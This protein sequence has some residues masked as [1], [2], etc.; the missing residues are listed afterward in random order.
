MHLQSV[1]LTQ[2]SWPQHPAGGHLPNRKIKAANEGQDACDSGY[3]EDSPMTRPF[4]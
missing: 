3:E 4:G 2:F 1:I